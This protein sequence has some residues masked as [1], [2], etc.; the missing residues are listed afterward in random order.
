M[1]FYISY[2]FYIFLGIIDY[3]YYFLFVFFF[4]LFV[5]AWNALYHGDTRIGILFFILFLIE[6]AIFLLFLTKF[7]FLI[8]LYLIIYV[9]AVA[10]LF[11]FSVKLVPVVFIKN[12]IAMRFGTLLIYCQFFLIFILF[13]SYVFLN[14]YI[15][16]FFY[17]KQLHVYIFSYLIYLNMLFYFFFEFFKLFDLLTVIAFFFNDSFF[18]TFF[19]F[20]Q[21]FFFYYYTMTLHFF[22]SLTY[23]PLDM[24]FLKYLHLYS[25]YF[26][27]G[28]DIYLYLFNFFMLSELKEMMGS[29][30]SING[31]FFFLYLYNEY[32]FLSWVLVLILL[33]VMV[34][35][36]S[37]ILF[38]RDFVK[39]QNEYDQMYRNYSAS[40]VLA[41]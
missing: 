12:L 20:T 39:H 26:S 35:A 25:Y 34:G 13:F 37:L 41:E 10:I 30:V 15:L 4:F 32:F 7:D 28:I 14:F 29:F 16:D 23:V 24:D 36:I 31:V 21:N 5:S 11:L 33:T 18:Y 6:L 2:L 17:L 38:H 8:L 9:G 40:I 1:N 22:T 27:L 3:Y 19:Y